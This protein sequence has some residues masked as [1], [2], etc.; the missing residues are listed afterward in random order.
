MIPLLDILKHEFSLNYPLVSVASGSQASTS[1][2]SRPAPSSSASPPPRPMPP[3]H[4]SPSMSNQSMPPRPAP[5]PSAN[6]P[7]Q[8]PMEHYDSRY[9]SP[10]RGSP[11]P[12]VRFEISVFATDPLIPVANVYSPASAAFRAVCSTVYRPLRAVSAFV[13]TC[14]GP[15]STVWPT[16]LDSA[17]PAAPANPTAAA[18]DLPTSS[19]ASLV[20]QRCWSPTAVV[21][22]PASATSCTSAKS[23]AQPQGARTEPARQRRSP[24]AF[25]QQPLRPV[26]C[27]APASPTESSVARPPRSGASTTFHLAASAAWEHDTVPCST[28]APGG[29]SGERTFRDRG[30]D[31][32]IGDC[33]GCVSSCSSTV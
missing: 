26:K 2:V 25:V 33:A 23:D 8:R 13:F 31:E 10:L 14:A 24:L 9:G 3:P 32:T 30:R 5:P 16:L 28:C 22:S 27:C 29:R 18:A 7:S 17:A 21:S 12:Q 15:A 4:A 19:T 11:A 20:H 6:G 1:S